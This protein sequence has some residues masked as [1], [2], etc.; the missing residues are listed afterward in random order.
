MPMISCCTRARAIV[1]EASPDPSAAK[2]LE[3]IGQMRIDAADTLVSVAVGP[4]QLSVA[5]RGRESVR[6][7]SWRAWAS[8][9]TPTLKILARADR[10]IDYERVIRHMRNGVCNFSP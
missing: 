6:C 5:F 4:K 3:I 9:P 1:S 7:F 2:E 8:H 10:I